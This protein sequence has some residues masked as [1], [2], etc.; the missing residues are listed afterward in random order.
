[1]N[2][3][4]R[5]FTLCIAF[6]LGGCKTAA[7]TEVGEP[8]YASDADTNMKRGAEALEG[9]NFVEAEKF[10]EYVRTKYPFLDLA[11]EAELKLADTDF[12]RD[13]FPEARDRYQTFVRLHP[14]HAKV[15]YAAFRG[16]L[17]HYKE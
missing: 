9:R 14:T 1:M 10:F 4:L 7:A 12:E 5:I 2:R 3:S 13:Q 8:D 17:T 16:A 15:D 6:V 11:K